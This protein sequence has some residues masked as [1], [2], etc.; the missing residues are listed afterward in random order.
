MNFESVWNEIKSQTSPY[1]AL[2]RQFKVSPLVAARRVLDAGY[3]KKSE[4][5][6]FYKQ[7]MVWVSTKK[8]EKKAAEDGGGNFYA[9]C[10]NRIGRPFAEAIARAAFA[11]RLLYRDAY[12]LTGLQGKTFDKYIAKVREEGG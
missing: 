12:K 8:A 4:F 10:D 1:G 5:F 9:N 7:Y 2:A 11:G 6:E 3:I